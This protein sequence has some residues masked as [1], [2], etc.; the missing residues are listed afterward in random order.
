MIDKL[1]DLKESQKFQSCAIN[2][3]NKK[4]IDFLRAGQ[5]EQREQ[6]SC[7]PFTKRE[8][9]DS[10]LDVDDSIAHKKR[11]LIAMV[12]LFRE[13]QMVFR[14]FYAREKLK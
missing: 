11:L 8:I 13:Q 10:V 12:K 14:L 9:E 6:R 1:T 7:K 4:V 3:V 5:R 2:I